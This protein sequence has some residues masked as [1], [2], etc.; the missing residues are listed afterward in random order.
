[1]YNKIS[2]ISSVL[3]ETIFR[4]KRSIINET[5]DYKWEF[6]NLTGDVIDIGGDHNQPAVNVNESMHLKKHKKVLLD[7]W[8]WRKEEIDTELGY[9]YDVAWEKDPSTGKELLLCYVLM[10]ASSFLLAEI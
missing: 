4:R 9:F 8:K 3:V 2:S 7:E 1:M 10:V 6:F 5:A